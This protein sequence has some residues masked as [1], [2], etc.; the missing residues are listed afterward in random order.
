MF[1][2]LRG[3]IASGV[4]IDTAPVPGDHGSFRF[5]QGSARAA[6][7][8]GDRFDVITTLAVLEHIPR[9]PSATSP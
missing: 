4:G 3:R 6:L 5:I 2:T 1:R 9:R 8:E 7:P